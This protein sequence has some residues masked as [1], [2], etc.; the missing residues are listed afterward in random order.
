MSKRIP[1]TEPHLNGNEWR[2]LK[3]CLDNNWLALGG[4]YI[5][6]FE[7]KMANYLGTRQ[8][9]ATVNGT[10]AIHIA[11]LLAGVGPEDLVLVPSLTFIGSVNPIRYCGAEPVF[12]DADSNTWNMDINQTRDKIKRLVRSGRKP[13]AIIAVHLYGL[14]VDMD[15]LMTL[16]GE[17][18]I[19]VIED[20]TE[21]LGALYKGSQA[22]SIGDLG[23]LSF[24]GNKLITTGG[25]GMIVTA[26]EDHART[27]RS[28]VSQAREEGFEY[29]H[30]KMG[31]NYRLP[32]ILAALGLA[33]LEQIDIFLAKKKMI[34]EFYQKTFSSHPAI[35]LRPRVTWAEESFWLYGML[36]KQEFGISSRELIKR[37]M[38]EGI[39][40]RP[41][42]Q[43]IH[44]QPI[45]KELGAQCPVA[46]SLW[47]N[48]VS[49]PSHV[50]LDKADLERV[51]QAVLR[52]AQE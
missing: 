30:K 33:Q 42:F 26:N 12:I 27:A 16:A 43:P 6:R 47:K 34:A 17:F 7:A 44:I 50:G 25:G 40:A 46:E 4:P 5:K 3:D 18:D 31:Y 22:G 14:P 29:F 24:N 45:Y 39:E 38:A 41:F 49:L 13:K 20:A 52:V 23:C 15:P 10:S 28:L 9:V 48:G 51:A 32:S 21:A 19:S 8:A 11:M 35:E 1:L 36:V 37:L 2:Y